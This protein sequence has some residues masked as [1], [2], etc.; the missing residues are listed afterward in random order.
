[1]NTDQIANSDSFPPIKDNLNVIDHLSKFL[2][3]AVS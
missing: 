1:M 2:G 3:L